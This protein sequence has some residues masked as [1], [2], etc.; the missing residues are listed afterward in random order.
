[1]VTPLLASVKP[2]PIQ[3]VLYALPTRAFVLLA[4]PLIAS[5][6]MG[7]PVRSVL[8]LTQLSL[9]HARNAHPI[10]ATQ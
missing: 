8:L 9:P 3:T 4:P 7:L 6:R 5:T 10:L 2:A 1:M